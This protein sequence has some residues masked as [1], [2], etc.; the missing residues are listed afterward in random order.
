MRITATITKKG[1]ITIPK[2]IRD[3]IQSRVIEF[4]VEDD[5]IQIKGVPSVEGS[6]STFT[7]KYVPLEVVRER[8]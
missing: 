3:K 8:V 4:V 7:N 1:Q 2:I 6:L 5:T